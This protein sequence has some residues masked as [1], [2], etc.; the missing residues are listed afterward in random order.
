MGTCGVTRDR[1][2]D[3]ALSGG[4]RNHCRREGYSEVG[5]I[6]LFNA[7]CLSTDYLYPSQQVPSVTVLPE[8]IF[9]IST[10]RKRFASHH[11]GT[12]RKRFIRLQTAA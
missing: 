1:I 7:R 5:H 9:C 2:L 10:K 11:N 12:Y 6:S 3:F 4:I 8:S